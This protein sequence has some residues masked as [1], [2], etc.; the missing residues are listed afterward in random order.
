MTG[1]QLEAEIRAALDRV[2]EPGEYAIYDRHGFLV[3][4]LAHVNPACGAE[5]VAFIERTA[6]P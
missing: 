2:S 1:D 5:F 6:E 3:R 4:W